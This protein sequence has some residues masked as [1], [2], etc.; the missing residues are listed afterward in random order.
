MEIFEVGTNYQ[1][2]ENCNACPKRNDEAGCPFWWE[3]IET[4]ISSGQERLRKQC[5]K[6]AMQVFMVEVI[7]ASNRPAAAVEDTRNQIVK[8]FE[9]LAAIATS[10]PQEARRSSQPILVGIFKKMLGR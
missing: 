2:A 6:S 1:N 8:G 5:G 4:N 7:K 10:N 3:W 9:N